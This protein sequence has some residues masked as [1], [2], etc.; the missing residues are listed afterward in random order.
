MFCLQEVGRGIWLLALLK[1]CPVPLAKFLIYTGLPKRL[2]SFFR[3]APRSLTE[4]VNELTDN[5]DLRAVFAYIF[6]T[7]GRTAPRL[8]RLPSLVRSLRAKLLVFLL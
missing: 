5:K 4:V 1:L 8:R 7:Y 2:S 6:G 3:M